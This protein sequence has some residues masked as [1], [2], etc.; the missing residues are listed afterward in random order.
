MNT[1]QK[2][3]RAILSLSFLCGMQ[4]QAFPDYPSLEGQFM[5]QSD[6]CQGV[7]KDANGESIIGASVL[8]K[9]TT[10]GSITGLD[11]DFSLKNVKKGDIIVVSYIGYQTQEIAWTGGP[12]NIVLKEDA[13]VLDEVV[14]IGYGAVRKAD[15][16]GSVAVLDNKKFKDQ[17]I[18]RVADALQGRVSGVHVENSGVPGGSVKIRV[19]GANSIS[20]SND[21][22]YVV[23]GIVRESGLDGINPE[24]IRSMQV[25]KDASST[26]IYGSR[27]ANGVVLI[28]TKS[29]KAGVREI[30]FDAS[31]GVS[32]LYKRYDIM[33]AYEYAQ[34]LREVK[35]TE[36]SEDQIALYRNRMA[37][38][39]WQDEIFRTGLTQN[40]KLAISNGSEKTQFY[41]SA[42]YMSQE[43]VVIESKNERY[44]AKVNISSQLTDWLHITG[45]INAAHSIRKGG[46]FAS[47]K[48]NP[49]WIAL[50]YSPSMEMMDTHGNYNKDSY[51]AIASNPVGILEIQGGETMADVFNGRLDLRFNICKGLTFTTTNGADYYDA[52]GYSFGSKRVQAQSSMGNND[53]YRLMLQSSNNLTYTGSWNGHNLTATAVYEVTSSET[54][55]MGINGTNLLTEGV[56][57]W[58]V[59]MAS[60]RNASNSYT[61]WAL[62]SGVGRVMYNYKDRYMLTGTF[63]ADG[64]SRFSNK[65]WGY[66]P[67]IAAA[68]T[69]SNEKFMK[70]VQAIEDLK[71]RGSFGIVGNQAITP[72]STLG[73]MSQT[74]YNFGTPNNFT[75]YWANDIPT[76]DLTWEDTRQFDLGVDFSLFNRRLN[77]GIDYFDKRTTNALL[78]KTMPGYKGGTSYWVNNGEISNRGV[79]IELTAHLFQNDDFSWTTTLNGTY[80]KNRVEKLAGGEDDFFYGSSPAPGMVDYATIIKPGEAIGSFWGYEW[81]GLD[82]KGNDV[83]LDVDES[84]VIDGSDRKIIGK[85]TPDFTLGWNNSLRYKNW[86]LNMFFNG[87]FGAKRMNLVR[88]TMASMVG[89]SRFVTLREAYEQGFDKV[90]NG[91]KYPSLTGSGNNYQPVSTKWLESADFFRLENISLSYNLSKKITKFADIRLTL[92]CQNLFTVSGYKGMDPAGT[93]FSNNN[94]DVD[95]G[96]DMGAYPT[97]RTF[98]FGVRMNF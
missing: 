11:G 64:S 54:R 35:G 86:E 88:F 9:G 31:V 27:G 87:S 47:G 30:M 3:A 61:K 74:S 57:W 18:T 49:I 13:E 92:S 77:I 65:K 41:I 70:D 43:G 72:Y 15:M 83:Y 45:D 1:L 48:G 58:N 22:L 51:N 42:N 93:T 80:L 85:A 29:G 12:L 79:D 33:N 20:K 69:L 75:G 7:V 82:E 56:G 14:V 67:S 25:L 66:F 34:A 63:R 8:V 81:T 46:G 59:N 5:Q 94:V 55:T 17:P 50:N 23:D 40:Y 38:I 21:P 90:G 95:A 19:R 78:T 98:T 53:T 2:T 84:G 62:M 32:N 71:L 68:W 4:V 76:P 37:G 36:F 44:S 97:P 26:A 89:D 73:L 16:A 10:N 39:D 28:T 96:I 52:K 91:A 24:D 60:A 6:I